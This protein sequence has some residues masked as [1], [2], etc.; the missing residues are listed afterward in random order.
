MAE[1]RYFMPQRTDTLHHRCLRWIGQRV[2]VRSWHENRAMRH[3]HPNDA[4]VGYVEEFHADVPESELLSQRPA[5]LPTDPAPARA[6]MSATITIEDA[7][8]PALPPALP[9]RP[10]EAYG[11]QNHHYS[12]HPP[13]ALCPTHG[14][15]R[16][17][18][19][20]GGN[21]RNYHCTE[22]GCTFQTYR[23]PCP[24]CANYYGTLDRITD[25]LQPCPWCAAHVGPTVQAGLVIDLWNAA[26]SW[27][28]AGQPQPETALTP[29]DRLAR[30][31]L[32]RSIGAIRRAG[33]IYRCL[34]IDENGV[35]DVGREG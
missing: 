6:T 5:V 16:M 15:A 4:R 33:G 2:T 27:E 17:N 29:T 13:D 31:L 14:F 21:H 30:D 24:V 22:T 7:I 11:Y 10:P 8:E 26:V 12:P 18:I 1:S 25:R 28:H 32:L 3:T 34:G 23:Y 9:P 20:Q 19:Y 35:P